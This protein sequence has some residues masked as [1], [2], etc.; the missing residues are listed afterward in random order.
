MW[1]SIVRPTE[2]RS[3]VECAFRP[4]VALDMNMARCLE[5]LVHSGVVPPHTSVSLR[6]LKTQLPSRS[7]CK[8]LAMINVHVTSVV[9]F[10]E[11]GV[12]CEPVGER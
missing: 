8:Y 11:V 1:R 6:L 12:E 7:H 4:P 3:V 5:L 2:F 10:Y 9:M